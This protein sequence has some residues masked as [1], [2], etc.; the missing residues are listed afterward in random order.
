MKGQKDSNLTIVDVPNNLNE[1]QEMKSPNSL[2]IGGGTY[3]QL[4]WEAGIKKPKRM[5]SIHKLSILQAIEE[6]EWEEKACIKIG[7]SVTIASC[8]KSPLIAKYA[9]ILS[10]ACQKIAAP[11][12]RNRATIG[13][14]IC[15]KVGDCIPV[16]LAL[17]ARL[18][19]FGEKEY[20]ISLNEWLSLENSDPDDLLVSILIPSKKPTSIQTF[21]FFHKVGRREAFTAA[22][23]SIAGY[24]ELENKKIQKVNLT[25]GGGSHVPCHIVKAEHELFHVNIENINWKNLHEIIK[26]GFST[27][28][29]PFVSAE[30][31][32]TISA[33]LFVTN[34]KR[35][36]HSLEGDG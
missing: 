8:L 5:I 32:K 11:A 24:I 26:A 21:A 12:V 7:S 29:D 28:T 10:E 2:I 17:D 36:V 23:I 6:V 16:L 34:L 20:T 9:S 3:M 33:N 18:Q 15:S 13:G 31:R 22:I 14:N 35:M 4:N 25:I 19:F 30:Y 27:Y 1:F